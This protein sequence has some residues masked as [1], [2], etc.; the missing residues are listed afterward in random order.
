MRAEADQLWWQTPF[1]CREAAQ[2][3]EGAAPGKVDARVLAEQ[4]ASHQGARGRRAGLVDSE[5]CSF[6]M[7]GKTRYCSRPA[8]AG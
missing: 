8:E 3:G 6:W 7:K 1:M 2:R 5:R 4:Y